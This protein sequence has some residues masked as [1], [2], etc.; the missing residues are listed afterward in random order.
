MHCHEISLLFGLRY[1]ELLNCQRCHESNSNFSRLLTLS[2]GLAVRVTRR[3]VA[4]V[5]RLRSSSTRR[6]CGM[7][8]SC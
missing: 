1:S 5:M 7:W 2:G 6:C 4:E 3:S 8:R